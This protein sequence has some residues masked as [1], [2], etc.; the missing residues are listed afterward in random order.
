MNNQSR[1]F[2]MVLGNVAPTFRHNTELQARAEAARL[3]RTNPGQAF[4][5]LESIA[6]VVKSDM[7][8][9]LHHPDAQDDLTIPF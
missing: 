5:V 9:S 8:W 6:T 7:S 3:A 2:W 1:T 4:T